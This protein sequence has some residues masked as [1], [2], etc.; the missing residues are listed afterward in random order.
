VVE[1]ALRRRSESAVLVTLMAL[2]SVTMWVGSPIFWLWLASQLQAGTQ[3]RMGPYL[4]V[5]AGVIATA[6][7]LTW[8]LR[9]FDA[10]FAHVNGV[11]QG[12]RVMLP[13]MR[14][15]RGERTVT[16][17]TSVLDV[18]MTVSVALALAAL[19]VFF[20]FFAGSPIG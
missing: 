11:R 12:E 9:R 14:S 6:A 1:S 2:G 18:V 17:R 3:P 4:L 15:M 13:W 10:R 20:F 7:A 16:R 5:L 8:L 19:G